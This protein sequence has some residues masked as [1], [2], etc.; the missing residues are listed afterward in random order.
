LYSFNGDIKISQKPYRF[1][2]K[3]NRL[4]GCS[5][6]HSSFT[7]PLFLFHN[8]IAIFHFDTIFLEFQRCVEQPIS[9]TGIILLKSVSEF[10]DGVYI[11]GDGEQAGGL[12]I[13]AGD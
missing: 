1:L 5:L 3:S 9:F 8:E 2:K 12:E 11:S 7:S 10:I 6:F 4:F 13:S